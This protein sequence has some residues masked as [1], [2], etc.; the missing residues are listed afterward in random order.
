MADTHNG[1]ARAA[2]M[3][4]PPAPAAASGLGASRR[5]TLRC[6]HCGLPAPR[7]L[8]EGSNAFCCR[9]CRTLH[10]FLATGR[11]AAAPTPPAP[12]GAAAPPASAR[13]TFLWIDGMHCSA[14]EV[15]IRRLALEVPGI[16]EAVSN[17]ATSTARIVYDPALIE[18]SA[19]PALLSRA[20]YRARLRMDSAPEPDDRQDLLRLF[21]GVCLASAVMMLSL[22]FLYPIHAGL[23]AVSEF[24]SIRAVA[25]E[26]APAAML[27]LTTIVVF[28]VGSP[29]LRGALTGLRAG[30]PTM[31]LLLAI[32]VVSAYGYSL[33]QLVADPLDLYFDVAASIVAV[34]TIGR[35][36]ERGARLRATRALSGL[37]KA[38]TP[39]ARVVRG[40]AFELRALDAIAPAD[41]IVVRPGEAVPVDGMVVSGRAAID[42]SLMT[43]EPFPVTR[44]PGAQVLGGAI[45]V[46]GELEIE[47]GPTLQ[48]RIVDLARVLWKVQSSTGGAQ[49][50]ADRIAAAFVPAV[51]ALAAAV[52]IG[53]L[54]AGAAPEAALLAG[55]ATLIVS[56]PCTFGL[57][58]PLTTAAAVSSALRRG[59][60]VTGADVFDKAP[61]FDIVAVDKTGTLSTGHMTV[62]EVVGPPEVARRAAAV[63]RLASHPVALAIAR[64]PTDHTASDVEI[65]PGRGALA[66][67]E[68]R[69]VAVGSRSLF[70]T[71]GWTVPDRVA[72]L[73]AGRVSGAAVISWVGWDGCVQ[74]AIV[75]RDQARPGWQD[76]VDRLRRHGRVVLLTGAAQ[77]GG[78]AD[79]VDAVHA[80]VLPESKAQIVRNLRAEGRVLMIGDGS[81]DAPALAAADL[82][83]AFGAPTALAAEAAGI[84]IPGH[85]L[86]RIFDAFDLIRVTRR[87]IRQNL[88]WA[89][90]YNAIAIPLAMT[91]LLNPLFAALAMSASSL[92]VV[93][94]ATRPIGRDE[95]SDPAVPARP[96]PANPAMPQPEAS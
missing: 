31:D 84:V 57:A 95:T 14:C 47:V 55:L 12:A 25:F 65:H 35:H 16:L 37:L 60:I 75:T 40:A 48:S 6:S 1:A 78:Y 27:V 42:E 94:N 3:T 43:G 72:G 10:R 89:L 71:L 76:V 46:E 86:D 91:G 80:G 49:A 45:V 20:G 64:L 62:V 52:A 23:V 70:D 18:E 67:V 34:V 2:A 96:A 28:Y 50:R 79:G 17:Y 4:S 39:V 93:F 83:I 13:E 92:L 38:W 9:G 77:P 22:A 8:R 36:L 66:S 87:R 59:I 30:V 81:N 69:R 58:I 51:L 63:E 15:V 32:S 41:H 5:A 53:L 73:L 29:I 19:L 68:G 24:D 74:G 56:C 85:R 11:P 44:G 90:L 7:P 61:R 21:A 88:G 54:V 82:G 33:R 26:I